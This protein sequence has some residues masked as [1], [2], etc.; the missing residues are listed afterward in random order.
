MDNVTKYS[1]A[2]Q[3]E[4]IHNYKR[5]K[6]NIYTGPVWLIDITRRAKLKQLTPKRI[7]IRIKATTN[8][9]SKLKIFANKYG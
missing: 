4:A 7:D 5:T 2:K 9:I 3:A 1:D 6:R 8:T